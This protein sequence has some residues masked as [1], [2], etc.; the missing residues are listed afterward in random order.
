MRMDTSRDLESQLKNWLLLSYKCGNTISCIYQV[1]LETGVVIINDA[2]ELNDPLELY[3]RT[4]ELTSCLA[5]KLKSLPYL[6]CTAAVITLPYP[7]IY[8]YICMFT[9]GGYPTSCS[10]KLHTNPPLG[11]FLVLMSQVVSPRAR[12]EIPW[13]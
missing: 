8:I 13:L 3:R 10:D 6:H 5:S 7:V 1:G 4:S 12:T 2:G 11:Y 9:S